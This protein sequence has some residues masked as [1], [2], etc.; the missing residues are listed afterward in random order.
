[1]ILGKIWQAIAA[2]FNKL[3]NAIR[4]YD[5]IAEM[6]YEY[7]RSVEQIREGREGLAQYRAMVERVQRQVD[8]EQKQ[9]SVLEARIKAYLNA[10]DRDAGRPD[11]ARAQAGQGRPRREREATG[12]ARAGVPEQP[13]EDPARR[14]EARRG[15]AQ[16]RQV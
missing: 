14:Q 5:P 1:M 8:G 12:P 15:Q 13:D 11:R 3:A 2:Q 4:G 6:Q 16:D 9:V 7:D 10:G